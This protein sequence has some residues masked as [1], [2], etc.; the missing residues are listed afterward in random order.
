MRE[1]RVTYTP[2]NCG[3]R[4]QEVEKAI[5]CKCNDVKPVYSNPTCDVLRR[6]FTVKATL[7][8][9]RDDVRQCVDVVKNIRY[10]KG[11]L[12]MLTIPMNDDRNRL[13]IEEIMPYAKQVDFVN[14]LRIVSS[15]GV[16][17]NH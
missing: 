8:E 14:S 10:P 4:R 16:M 11:M 3:C 1:I 13:I 6:E 5:P 2:E 17:R 12:L 9:W 15:P 7:K